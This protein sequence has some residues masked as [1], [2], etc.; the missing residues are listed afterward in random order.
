MRRWMLMA[1]VFAALLAVPPGVRGDAP[2]PAT[3]RLWHSYRGSERDA[4]ERVVAEFARMHPEWPVE[5]LAVPY[6]AFANKLTSAIPRGNGPDVFIAAHERLGDWVESGLIAGLPES[7]AWSGFFPA[8]VEAVTWKG[9]QFG[10]PLAFKSLALFVRDDVLGGQVPGDTDSLQAT[11]RRMAAAR[12]GNFCIAWEAGSFYHHAPWVFGFGGGILDK[13][14]TPR[15]DR[16]ENAASVAFVTGLTKDGHMPQEPTSALI[17]QLFNEG[18]VAMVVNGPWFL[19]E[20]APGVKYSVHPLPRVSS[21]GLPATPFLTVDA[22]M[23]SSKSTMPEAA[24]ALARFLAV[25]GA[26]ARLV[27]ARQVVTLASA[28]DLPDVVVDPIVMQFREAAATAIPMPNV[29]V[30]RAVWEPASQALRAALRG[31]AEPEAAMESAMQRI[32]IATRPRPAAANPLFALAGLAILGI[33][34]LVWAARRFRRDDTWSRMRASSHAYAFLAPAAVATGVLVF[35]PFAVGTGV[36]FFSHH[37]GEFTYVGLANFINILGSTDYAVTEPLSF[38]F[39]LGVTVMWT[40]VNVF[41]HVSIG[42]A[43]ALVLRRPWMK[44]RGVYRVLLIVPWAVPN[45]ITALIWKGMFHK[46]FGAVNGLLVWLGLEPVSW[47]S[48]FWTSFA[49]NVATNTWLG[50]PFMMVVTLGALQSIPGELEEA[51]EMDGATA[52]Q[53]F[54]SITLPLLKPALLPAIVLGGV[55]TFNMFNIIFLVSGG[56]PGGSTEILISEAYRWAFSRQEQYGYAAAY[57]TLI[58]L[59]LL[60]WSLAAGRLQRRTA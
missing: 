12:P 44:L 53:R 16:P 54:F 37:Q 39:T 46:Q 60:A 21:T 23:V 22:A 56:E 52:V 17:T 4:L 50:F 15:L 30:M 11:C 48:N 24:G 14:G 35:V 43:L 1:L 29:P 13:D 59:F 49:A 42:V 45:Y 2:A 55:W 40:V 41:M 19:G 18:R 36:A 3:L 7:D 5:L 32:E 6:E 20:L 27:D 9:R 25:E 28:W 58:F 57:A 8:T 10:Y 33:A 38:W 51:A 34:A 31:A 26:T 47:F